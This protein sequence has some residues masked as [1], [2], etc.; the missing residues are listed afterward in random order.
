[1]TRSNV[2]VGIVGAGPVGLATALLLSSYGVRSVVL[3][4]E[5]TLHKLGSRASTI[6]GDVLELLDKIDCAET[7]TDEGVHWNVGRTYVR[8]QVLTTTVYPD[9][10]GFPAF[11]NISQHRTQQVMLE[12]LNEGSLAEIRWAHRVTGVSQ[13]GEAV[14]VQVATP[15]GPQEMRFAYLVAAD[16]IQSPLRHLS[17]AEW[18]GSSHGDR[19]LSV[20][21]RTALPFAHERHFHYDHPANPGRQVVMHAQPGDLW[22]VD[23]QLP[24]DTDIEA[25]QQSDALDRRIRATLGDVPYEIDWVSTYRFDHRVVAQMKLGRIFFAGDAAHA[26]PPY[27]A[28]GMNSGIQD[29]DNLAW[30]LA[31]VVSGRSDESLLDTYHVERH[32]AARENLRVTE[33]TVKFMVPPGRVNRW[34]RNTLLRLASGFGFLRPHVDSG[35]MAEPFAYAASPIVERRGVADRLVGSFAPDGMVSVDGRP[36]RLRELLGEVFVGLYFDADRERAAGF[37]E[38]ALACAGTVPVAVHV[39][40]DDG[41]ELRAAYGAERPAWFLVR[42]DGHIAATG[43]GDDAAAF[44]EA[45]GRCS[46]DR[47]CEDIHVSTDRLPL[48]VPASAAGR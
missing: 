25:E 10:L 47:S 34:A 33:A 46:R 38:R 23:W 4:A 11:V 36:A 41:P 37:A 1:M 14:T 39:I 24:A 18:T 42:P 22:R 13:D 15:E 12:R 17:G 40:H 35:R 6:Q 32:A 48:A 45:V 44:A 43:D 27:G 5:P 8:G 31:L 20:D 3:E 9:R 2:P 7:L 21:L 30:K 29:A 26:L 16:G 28:R 19:F